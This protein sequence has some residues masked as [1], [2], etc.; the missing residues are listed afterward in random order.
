MDIDWLGRLR[1]LKIRQVKVAR[2]AGVS[3]ACVSRQLHHIAPVSEVVERAMREL[4]HEAVWG[5]VV[6]R[7]SGIVFNWHPQEGWGLIVCTDIANSGEAIKFQARDFHAGTKNIATGS[8]VSFD[9]NSRTG[10]MTNATTST[11]LTPT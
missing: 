2:R 4:L 9:L 6:R 11:R 1:S 3:E 7:C 10:E 5:P 8:V